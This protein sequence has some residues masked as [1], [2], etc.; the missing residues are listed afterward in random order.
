MRDKSFNNLHADRP[1]LGNR[2]SD[3]QNPSL[4]DE[5]RLAGSFSKSWGFGSVSAGPGLRVNPAPVYA[6]GLSRRAGWLVLVARSRGSESGTADG[7][8][9]G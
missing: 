6:N 1:H 9:A 2:M 7:L 4:N 3:V 8:R 5:C